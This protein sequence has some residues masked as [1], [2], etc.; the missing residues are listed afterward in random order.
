MNENV[1]KSIWGEKI[2]RK[3][4]IQYFTI[5]NLLKLKKE[6]ETI[7]SR[8]IGDNFVLPFSQLTYCQG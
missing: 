8:T 4:N 3:L 5:R 1:L 7:K 6:N 2:P